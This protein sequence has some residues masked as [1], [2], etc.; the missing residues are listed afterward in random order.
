[1]EHNTTT[2]SNGPGL[3][4]YDFMLRTQKVPFMFVVVPSL[5]PNQATLSLSLIRFH[6]ISVGIN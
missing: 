3:I 1:M 6:S 5:E 2:K 4:F